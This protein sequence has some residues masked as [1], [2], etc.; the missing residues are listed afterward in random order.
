[1]SVRLDLHFGTV[2]DCLCLKLSPVIAWHCGGN[3][4]LNCSFV[5]RERAQLRQS[6][7]CFLLRSIKRG[8]GGDLFF[9]QGFSVT[10]VWIEYA[11]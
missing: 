4:S 9:S 1:M 8:A 10:E 3:Q 5:C 7:C 2:N 11:E 6:S